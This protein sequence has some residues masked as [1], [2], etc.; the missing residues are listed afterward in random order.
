[1]EWTKANIDID[2]ERI[3]MTTNGSW[4]QGV[5]YYNIMPWTATVGVKLNLEF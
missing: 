2:P 1:M 3:Y 5:E 4:L